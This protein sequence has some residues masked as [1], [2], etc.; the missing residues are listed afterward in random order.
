MALSRFQRAAEEAAER[1]CD[2]NDCPGDGTYRAPKSPSAL[3]EHFWFCLDHVREY[4]KSWD[5]FSDM[6]PDEIE[7]YQRDDITG[8]RPTW[9]IGMNGAANGDKKLRDDFGVFA[10]GGRNFDARSKG[11]DY[12]KPLPT[13]QRDALAEMNLDPSASLEEIKTRYKALAK[14]YHP[15]VNGDDHSAEEQFKSV[16]QAYTY[17]LNC[18]YS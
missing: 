5:Y 14:K 1:P 10:I 7:K 2:H 16:N 3:N 11:G 13:P 6:S 4:N 8:H 9:R 18:G 12:L 17:L 15:D